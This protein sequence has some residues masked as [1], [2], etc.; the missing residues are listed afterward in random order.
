VGATGLA[1]NPSQYRDRLREETD[2]QIDAW[3]EEL[4]RDVAL[5]RGVAR[6]V[7]DVQRAAGLDELSFRRVFGRG[8]GPAA[9]I[10]RDAQG[11]PMV[12]AVTLYCLVRGLRIEVPDARDRLIDY[13]VGCFDEIVYA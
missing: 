10:G 1:T 4:M 2:Q 12:P 7:A 6:V 3:A 11:R 9:S 13:L 8:G 5:R